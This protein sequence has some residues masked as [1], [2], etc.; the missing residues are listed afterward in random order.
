MCSSC[1]GVNASFFK[2][3]LAPAGF[4]QCLSGFMRSVER[5]PAFGLHFLEFLCVP[6]W[7]MKRILKNV[8]AQ[9]TRIFRRFALAFFL[10]IGIELKF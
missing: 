2:R 5:W 3:V 4:L 10:R 9:C 8:A 7:F 1:D 6:A